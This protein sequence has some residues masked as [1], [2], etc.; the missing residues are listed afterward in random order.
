MDDLDTLLAEGKITASE[1][2]KQ[3]IERQN[4]YSLQ[5]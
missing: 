5:F 4:S 2:A 3:L 1:Y